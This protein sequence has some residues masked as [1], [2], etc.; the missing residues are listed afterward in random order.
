MCYEGCLEIF[1]VLFRYD[2]MWESKEC[3]VR[4]AQECGGRDSHRYCYQYF[5]FIYYLVNLSDAGLEIKIFSREFDCIF[6]SFIKVLCISSSTSL[7][8][9]EGAAGEF[10]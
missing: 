5:V 6:L 3:R 1:P 2:V 4:V 8:K 10:K 9:F 7:Q